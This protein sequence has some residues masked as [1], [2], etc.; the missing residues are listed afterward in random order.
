[1]VI[2]EDQ[3]VNYFTALQFYMTYVRNNLR[4]GMRMRRRPTWLLFYSSIILHDT[5]TQLVP[6]TVR[7]GKVSVPLR[8]RTPRG[9]RDFYP[10]TQLVPANVG[11]GKLSLVSVRLSLTRDWRSP[12]G[13]GTSGACHWP[14]ASFRR[15]RQNYL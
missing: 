4:L 14:A 10:G 2:T 13:T 15:P 11:A 6:A 9:E 5:G 7:T 12:L 1:M 8:P 3:P